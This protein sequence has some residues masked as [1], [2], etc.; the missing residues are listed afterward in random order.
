MMRITPE[1]RLPTALALVAL[2][3]ALGGTSYA[4][5]KLKKGSVTTREIK[6]ATVR[7]SDLAP[8]VALSGPR[9]P[10]GAEG[11]AGVAGPT[12]APGA[13]G[14]AKLYANRND[15]IRVVPSTGLVV[16]SLRLPAGPYRFDFTAH[17]FSIA[18]STFIDC[19]LQID[20][21]PAINGSTV[22]IGSD[23]P[24]AIEQSMA[25]LEV[26]TLTKTSTVTLSCA[27]RQ[28]SFNAKIVNTRFTAMPVT[29][30]ELQ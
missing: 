13:Q 2:F 23:A 17:M 24:G 4:A 11:P 12:G 10:R 29:S 7:S 1:Q 21:Q 3:V 14:V 30:V 28:T 9:G 20:G 26:A 22:T 19:G 15:A 5:V 25:M 6:D 8:G 18:A 16:G 27:Q